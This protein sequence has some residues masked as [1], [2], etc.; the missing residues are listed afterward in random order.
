MQIL[1][2]GLGITIVLGLAFTA[3]S[4]LGTW[5]WAAAM[6]TLLASLDAGRVAGTVPHYKAAEIA[7]LP[8]PVRRYFDQALTDGQPIIRTADITRRAAST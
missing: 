3:A 2:W 7:T 5:R 1:T 8:A 4:A 6:R